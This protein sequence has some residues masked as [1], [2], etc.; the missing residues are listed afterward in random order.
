MKKTFIFFILSI[1]AFTHQA[2]SQ[3]PLI[4]QVAQKHWWEQD[5]LLELLS[6]LDVEVIEDTKYEQFIDKSIIV[7]SSNHNFEGSRAY[8]KALHEKGYTYGVILLSDELYEVMDDFCPGAKFVFRNYWHKAFLKEPKV[9]MFAL[10]YKYGFWQNAE[11]Q[12]PDAF[13]RDFTWSFAGQI[14]KK[15]TREAMIAQLK[16]VPNHHIHETFMWNDSK[17]LDVST[18]RN[19]MLNT[20]FVPCPTGFWNLDSF[21]LYETLECGAIPIVEKQPLDYFRRFYGD[22]PFLVINSWDEAPELMHALLADPEKLEALRQACQQWWIEY[23]LRTNR[24]F[25]TTIQDAFGLE[26]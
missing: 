22:H 13:H 11:K 3:T 25:V 21:R 19:L 8:C 18:Y 14:T 26:K 1:F 9:K 16:S 17:G 15:P 12:I 20:I 24:E 7:F 6:G 10:G 5:Y 2:N 4:W 23:K